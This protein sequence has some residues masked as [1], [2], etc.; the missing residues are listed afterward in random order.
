[1]DVR[2]VFRRVST[3]ACAVA[4]PCALVWVAAG[5]GGGGGTRSA[6]TVDVR[7]TTFTAPK[8]T[9]R[10][11]AFTVACQPVSGT[12]PFAARI[13]RDI[14]RH[15]QAMLDPPAARWTCIGGPFMPELTVTA[16]RNGTTTSFEGSPG[17]DWPAGT[18]LAVYFDAVERD[19]HG[20]A[21]MEPRLRCGEDPVLLARPTPDASAVACVRG[22]WT[23]RTERLIRTAER[24]PAIA[25]LGR[26]LFPTEIG[27]EPCAIPAGGPYRQ[28]P[29]NGLCEVTVKRVWS[30]PIVTFVES[31]PRTATARSRDPPGDDPQ[32]DGTDHRPAWRGSA[33]VQAL[34]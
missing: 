25:A 34:T 6:I 26:S 16:T 32:R 15:P 11:R 10:V 29:L 7:L 17:C 24:L 22:L 5:C 3:V 20:L 4:V 31:W 28:K 21:L 18:A 8:M 14:V 13:C 19:L 12:L 23:P 27:A 33:A 1:M 30:T 2:A 9:R